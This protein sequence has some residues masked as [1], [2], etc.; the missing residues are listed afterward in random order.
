MPRRAWPGCATSRGIKPLPQR[1]A[2]LIRVYPR[3]PR[4]RRSHPPRDTGPREIS[5]LVNFCAFSCDVVG[6]GRHPAG[7]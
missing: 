3:N 1:L 5:R 7:R 6:K 2:P 4:E